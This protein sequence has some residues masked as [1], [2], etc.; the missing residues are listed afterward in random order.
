MN[1]RESVDKKFAHK[2]IMI[3]V[4]AFVLTAIIFAVIGVRIYNTPANRKDRHLEM[5]T[6]YLE[7]Q[8][9]RQA[10]EEFDR[11]IEID[12][13]GVDAYLGKV[14]AYEGMGDGANVTKTLQ[15]GYEQNGDGQIKER[16]VGAWLGQLAGY[17]EGE[18]YEN[19]LLICDKLLELDG[20]NEQVRTT[21]GDCLMNYIE[22]MFDEERYDEVKVLIEKYQDTK[23][24]KRYLILPS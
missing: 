15:A 20:E 24:S 19:A 22:R 2:G 7:E 21:V 5:A 17:A 12:P 23:K 11:V 8:K 18:D 4:I 16:L 9:Y 6:A 10:L 14:Q 13:M 1:K 3:A